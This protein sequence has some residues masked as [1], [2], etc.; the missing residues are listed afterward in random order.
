MKKLLLTAVALV[1]FGC[2]VQTSAFTQTADETKSA[3]AKPATPKRSTIRIDKDGRPLSPKSAAS[4][5]AL[6]RADCSP[7]KYDSKTGVGIH[8]IY[9]SYHE[10]DPNLVSVEGKKQYAECVRLCAAPLPNIYVQ[11]AVFGAG[12]SWFGKSKEGCLDCHAKGH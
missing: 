7:K 4:R 3:A 6:C 1:V 8:G 10:F 9:R 5:N 11:R 2:L 12:M